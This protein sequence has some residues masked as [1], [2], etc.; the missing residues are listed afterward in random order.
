MEEKMVDICEK[1]G[2]EYK[3][4]SDDDVKSGENDFSTVWVNININIRREARINQ[5]DALVT[6]TNDLCV[7]CGN[8]LYDLL[9]TQ[10]YAFVRTKEANT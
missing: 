8:K 4:A 6:E 2:R 7:E 10:L 5:T 9:K 3:T 1:C